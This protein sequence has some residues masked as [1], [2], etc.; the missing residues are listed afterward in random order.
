LAPGVNCRGQHAEDVA[1]TWAD[2]CCTDQYAC[3]AIYDKF[4][5]TFVAGTMQP[6]S[7][8]RPNRLRADDHIQSRRASGCFGHTN[9]SD[10]GISESDP[11]ER[12]IIR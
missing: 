12:R 1:A 5:H 6:A 3:V 9:R 7:E 11:W 2:G 10:L 4:D 8:G